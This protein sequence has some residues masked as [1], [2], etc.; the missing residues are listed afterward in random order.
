MVSVRILSWVRCGMIATSAQPLTEKANHLCNTKLLPKTVGCPAL[1]YQSWPKLRN[2]QQADQPDRSKHHHS[3]RTTI[4]AKLPKQILC[5][6]LSQNNSYLALCQASF[7]SLS[8]HPFLG[9]S[10]RWQSAR[11]ASFSLCLRLH[12]SERATSSSARLGQHHL[13]R[14]S[15]GMAGTLETDPRT[16][17][18][19]TPQLSCPFRQLQQV[20]ANF[21]SSSDHW[22]WHRWKS[23][24]KKHK[25][26]GDTNKPQKQTCHN[27]DAR[28]KMKRS[29]SEKRMHGKGSYPLTFTSVVGISKASPNSPNV[30]WTADSEFLLDLLPKSLRPCETDLPASDATAL[31]VAMT[32]AHEA[33]ASNAGDRPNQTSY[34]WGHLLAR[35]VL[36]EWLRQFLSSPIY[37]VA[38]DICQAAWLR[39][40]FL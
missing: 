33:S 1:W 34:H 10:A 26:S 18:V 21:L 2:H 22:V 35:P 17:A 29:Q 15:Y 14:K 31:A 27:V 38:I 40:A 16:I 3:L 32:D 36:P 39:T 7:F 28:C 4:W 23:C 19:A 5:R 12:E 30:L 6:M 20:G 11:P 9:L 8:Q 25:Q 24:R 37:T 13:P